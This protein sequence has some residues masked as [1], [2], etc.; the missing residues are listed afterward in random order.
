MD[1]FKVKP[2]INNIG[3][4]KRAEGKYKKYMHYITNGNSLEARFTEALKQIYKIPFD[5]DS[6]DVLIFCSDKQQI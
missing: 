5:K 2:T 3:Y 6:K 1:Y 4:I